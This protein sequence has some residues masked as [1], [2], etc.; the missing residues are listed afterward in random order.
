AEQAARLCTEM[1]SHFPLESYGYGSNDEPSKAVFTLL[2]DATRA[3][4]M[5]DSINLRSISPEMI[6]KPSLL[7]SALLL[8]EAHILVF[9]QLVDRNDKGFHIVKPLFSAIPERIDIDLYEIRFTT[10][11]PNVYLLK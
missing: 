5:I 11:V 9:R 1:Q 7:P 4:F 10:L 2:D 8:P 3:S 6:A